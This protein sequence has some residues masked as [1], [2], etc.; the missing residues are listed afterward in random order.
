MVRCYL[1][2][3]IKKK[4]IITDFY[5][6]KE[7]MLILRFSYLNVFTQTIEIELHQSHSFI[8]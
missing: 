8:S 3:K 2:V 4:I 6:E 5:Y 7:S 1:S